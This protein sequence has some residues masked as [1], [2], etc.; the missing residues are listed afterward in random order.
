MG[1]LSGNGR[2]TNDTRRALIA[3]LMISTSLGIAIGMTQQTASAQAAAQTNF[4]V[5]AGPLNQA[6]MS[7]GRQT[8]LQVTYLASIAA[9]KSSPGFSGNGTR[10]QA[11]ASILRGSGLTYSFPNATTAAI[12]AS[13]PL[14]PGA[15]VAADGSTLLETITVNGVGNGEN[16]YV[17][18]RSATGTKTDAPLAEVPQ[19]I[20]IVGRKQIEA[21]NAQSVSEILRYVPGV[22]IETYGPD[23]KGYDWIL[24]RGFNAQSTSSYL[25][26]LRQISSG[27]SFF[28][29]DPYQ[30]QSV[31]VLR[32]PSSSLYGQS[33]AGGIVNKVSKKPTDT[34]VRE[35]ELEYGSHQR[36]Q[37]G[38]DLG[39]PVNDDKSIMYRVTGV[40]RN[41]NTQFQYPDGTDIGDDRFMIAPSITWAPDSD[42]S[43]TVSGQALRDKSGG[44]VLMFT[45]TNTLIGDHSFNNSVQEQQTIGYEFSHRFND[46]WTVRQNLRYGRADFTLDNLLAT[47]MDAS[48]NLIRGTRRFDESL[49]AL[50]IDNQAQANF[51]TGI[52]AHE[53]LLGLDYARSEADVKRYRGL[54]PSLDPSNP[55]YGVSIPQPTTAFADYEE[56]YQ[57]IGLYA[58]DRINLTD[59]LIATLGGRYD[60]V[61]IDTANRLSNTNPSVDVGNFSGRAGLTYKTPWGVAPY[62]SYAQSFVPNTGISSSGNSF[63]PSTGRQW[64]VGVKYEP[65]G[66]DALFTVAWFDIVKSNI[67]TPERNGAGV[68]TGFFVATGEV[69]S[70]GVEVEGKFSLGSGWDLTSS[71]TWTNAEITRDNSGFVGKTP[72]LVPEHQASAWLNYTVDDGMLE[73]LSIGGGVRYVG[74]SFGDNANTVKVDGRAL[75]DLGASYK[76]TENASFSVNATNVFDKSYYTTCED[77]VSCYEGDRR[78]VIGRLKVNF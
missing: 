22:T 28:R 71:Y 2:K 18:T 68:T 65:V 69:Q 33:D 46:T 38:F 19:S 26:G 40:A 60:W 44:T 37:V 23:P 53:L 51:D 75:I 13:G 61:D 20:S 57:Q 52:F 78:S 34:P 74:D 56:T 50:T 63:D 59:N 4:S 31:E 54:A 5:N 6:L 72:Y 7:F 36:A 16:T 17:V 47:G 62:V 43:L 55:V 35:V 15:N 49:D 77:S 73:G 64:E 42:T 48:G 3:A 67:L 58:Q 27:Y 30:L 39:G 41:S 25:D 12:A 21:Q 45:P 9:G 66:I 11:L 1:Q 10:E 14:V 24:M 29:T 70:R 76:V 32:G 8:G